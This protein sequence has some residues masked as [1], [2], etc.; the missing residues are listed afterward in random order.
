M[1]FGNKWKRVA[2]TK[3]EL[4]GLRL[5]HQS[6]TDEGLSP[7]DIRGALNS[8]PRKKPHREGSEAQH[9]AALTDAARCAWW[10]PGYQHH[11]Q[12]RVLGHE[13][14]ALKRRGVK[15]GWPDVTLMI[16]GG[17]GRAPVLAALELKVGSNTA[18]DAQLDTLLRLHACGFKTAVI[19]GWPEALAWLDAQAGPRPDV[20][21]TVR[22]GWND[23]R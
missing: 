18:T 6:A 9:Q 1:R 11:E 13:A 17:D 16:P 10:F 22:Q 4:D 2:V 23:D 14:G 21:P 8:K 5:L 7:E 12:A 15:A 19:W 3:G 20:M